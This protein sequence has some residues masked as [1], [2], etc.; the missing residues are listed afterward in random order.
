MVRVSLTHLVADRPDFDVHI[1]GNLVNTAET[2][3]IAE[4]LTEVEELEGSAKG[5]EGFIDEAGGSG[6]CKLEVCLM[7]SL[8]S[9]LPGP[10]I[11]TT[12]ASNIMI[13]YHP[14]SKRGTCI[15]SSEEYKASLIDD[16]E[17]TS[18]PDN[19]P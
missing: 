9:G 12:K 3:E 13:E 4:D 10:H 1:T 8:T 7:D 19:K 5:S 18:L 16:S 2:T 11:Q 6:E 15:M 14:H 17:P